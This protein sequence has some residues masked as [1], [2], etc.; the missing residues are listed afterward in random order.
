MAHDRI[1]YTLVWK[2][3]SH[4]L[5]LRISRTILRF[6]REAGKAVK[7]KY[8]ARVV[9]NSWR[10]CR[11]REIVCRAMFD[12]P[13]AAYY[14]SLTASSPLWLLYSLWPTDTEISVFHFIVFHRSSVSARLHYSTSKLNAWVWMERGAIKQERKDEKK[15]KIQ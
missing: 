13:T 1:Y 9:Y 8:T 12:H 14:A 15:K 3:T 6:H 7:L 4:A 2:S 5:Y 10:V 11:G